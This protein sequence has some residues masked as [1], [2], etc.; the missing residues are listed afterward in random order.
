MDYRSERQRALERA[1]GDRQEASERLK[2][3]IESLAVNGDVQAEALVD[4]MTLAGFRQDIDQFAITREGRLVV[5]IAGQQ[6]S[7]PAAKSV[8]RRATNGA[9][10]QLALP[11]LELTFL[12]IADKLKELEGQYDR[13]FKS[14]AA[15]ARLLEL[16]SAA[17]TART[18]REALQMLGKSAEEWLAS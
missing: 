13:L 11:W 8:H 14:M 12:E 5:S 1:S 9:V 4:R 3:R 15:A 7:V 16:R 17:P 6:D 2:E 18:P 10:L